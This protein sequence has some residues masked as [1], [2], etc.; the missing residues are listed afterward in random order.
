[1]VCQASLDITL[2]QVAIGID[3]PVFIRLD[4]QAGEPTTATRVG[5]DTDGVAEVGWDVGFLRGVATDHRLA[6]LVRLG[7]A[8]FFVNQGKGQLLVKRDVG[9]K[10]GVHKD[11]GIGFEVGP[12]FAQEL[13]VRSRDVI[14]ATGTIIEIKLVGV[15]GGQKGGEISNQ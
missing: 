10:V 1:M 5:I 14:K 4:V 11:M 12:V 8:K 7:R 6:R 3:L 13:P 9:L 2:T 15:T